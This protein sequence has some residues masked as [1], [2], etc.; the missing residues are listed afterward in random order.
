MSRALLLLLALAAPA[1][2]LEVPYLSGRV[3]DRA[4]LLSA[5][6]SQA[7]EAK[8]KDFEARTGH[9]VA[10]LTLN[11]LEGEPLEDFSLK[12][13]RTW[14]LGRK[15]QN[16]GVLFL[17]SKSDRKLRI[18]VGHGLEGNIPDAL[19]GRI[20]QN[21]VVPRF[22]AGDFEGGVA[23][24]VDAIVAAAEGAYSPPPAPG[25]DGDLNG[26]G[27]LEKLVTSAF[28]LGMLGLFEVVGLAAPGAGW[29]LY[30]FLIPFWAAFPM[31]IWGAK[32][33]MGFLMTHLIGFPFV[34]F[35]LPH[36]S[37]GRNF[38]QKG[39][40]VYYG[41]SEIFTIGGGSGS[42][43]GGWSSGGSS[44]GFSGGGGSFGGGGS[45]GS[46]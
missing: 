9:Q 37:F 14:A 2:A 5:S 8:L 22:R 34:K 45:S 18:E 26:M 28:V 1:A 43:G 41:S 15:G 25:E 19:A 10:V 33:G 42:S 7:V 11:S 17:I 13:S 23:A 32:I 24:G 29:F 20:I 6:A 36:T 12:V 16:D 31:G 21:E 38:S 30:F 46:W 40:K 4:G 39:N 44:G 35:L 3:N 27:L